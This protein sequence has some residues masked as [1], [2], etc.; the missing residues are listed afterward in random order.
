[1]IAVL[2]RDYR[3]RNAI[4]IQEQQALPLEDERKP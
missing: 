4:T 1:M 2:I 3:G